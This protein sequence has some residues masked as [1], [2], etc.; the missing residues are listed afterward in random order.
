MGDLPLATPE[1]EPVRLELVPARIAVMQRLPLCDQDAD[2]FLEALE[3]GH[4]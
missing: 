2:R 1:R 4:R 3:A